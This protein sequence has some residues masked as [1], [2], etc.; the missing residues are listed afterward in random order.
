MSRP[1][2]APFGLV[3]R[4]D[5]SWTH[6]GQPILNRRLREHFDRS[7]AYL[8]E[9]QKYIVELRHFRAE[10]EIEEAGFFVRVVDLEGGT[11]SLSDGTQELL[12][13]ASLELSPIDGALMCRIKR[14]LDPGG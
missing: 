14:E 1:P 7:V 12:D 11:V 9:E 13:P 3:L 5:G 8:P 4:H 2:L 10:I 6:E